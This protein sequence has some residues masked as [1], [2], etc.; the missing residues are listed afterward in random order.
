MAQV[1]V[2]QGLAASLS[3]CGTAIAYW[4]A[5]TNKAAILVGREVGRV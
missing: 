1:I 2:S 5:S 4:A 3:V